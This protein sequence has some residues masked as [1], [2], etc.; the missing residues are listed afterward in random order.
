MN[1]TSEY[2]YAATPAH[3]L[4]FTVYIICIVKLEVAV[5][6]VIYN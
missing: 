1:V 4:V 6:E 5:S 2:H 3:Y